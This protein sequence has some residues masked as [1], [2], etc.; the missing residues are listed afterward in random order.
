LTPDD[1]AQMSPQRRRLR[2]WIRMKCDAADD[3]RAA[4]ACLPACRVLRRPAAGKEIARKPGLPVEPAAAREAPAT[5]HQSID[6]AVS[7]H[8]SLGRV[9]LVQPSQPQTLRRRA[10]CTIIIQS[11]GV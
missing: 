4:A 9:H 11:N 6:H 5:H 10:L 1:S 3:A 7:S 2:V 8:D